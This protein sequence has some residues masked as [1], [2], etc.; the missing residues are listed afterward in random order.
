MFIDYSINY[1][2][3]DCVVLV[4][5]FESEQYNGSEPSGSVEVV[6]II[7]GGSSAIPININVTIRTSGHSTQREE[8]Y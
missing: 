4:V 1:L 5:E 7:S 6:V 8:Y 2:C 3:D